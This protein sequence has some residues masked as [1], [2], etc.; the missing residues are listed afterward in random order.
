[1]LRRV[2]FFYTYS[3]EISGILVTF[4]LSENI[5]RKAR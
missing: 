4:C 5:L 3:R 2:L 1:M